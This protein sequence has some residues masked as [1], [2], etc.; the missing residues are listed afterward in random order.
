MSRRQRIYVS[1]DTVTI[2]KLQAMAEKKGTF[3]SRVIDGLVAALPT[4]KKQRRKK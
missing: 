1:L 4:P 3:I 2:E